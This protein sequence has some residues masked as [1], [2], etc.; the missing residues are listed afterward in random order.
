GAQEFGIGIQKFELVFYQKEVSTALRKSRLMQ[1]V[2]CRFHLQDRWKQN[3]D[4]SAHLRLRLDTDLTIALLNN[5]IHRS[6]AQPGAASQGHGGKERL[7]GLDAGLLIHAYA[8]I[9]N[10][11]DYIMSLSIPRRV[12]S[13]AKQ[14]YRLNE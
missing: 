12:W 10:S 7:K 3:S 13:R 2:F 14:I 4:L 9:A 1:V 8:G 6:Q 5:A 11:N